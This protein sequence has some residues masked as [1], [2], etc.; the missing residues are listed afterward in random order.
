LSLRT[1]LKPIKIL[2]ITIVFGLFFLNSIMST[3]AETYTVVLTWGSQGSANNQFLDSNGIA[4]DSVGN[5]YVADSGNYRIQKFSNTGEFI[6]KWGSSGSADGYFSLPRDVVVD[7]VGNVYVADS[8]NYRIQKFSNTGEFI[9]KWG[10]RGSADSQFL[11]I[12]GIAVDSVGNVYVADPK[13]YRIQKFSNTGEFIT[14][15]GSRGSADSQFNYIYSTYEYMGIDIDSVGNVY[16]A[17]SGNRRIQKFSNTGEFITKYSIN[18]SM[19]YEIYPEQV[20]VDSSGNAYITDGTTIYKVNSIGK[21]TTIIVTNKSTNHIVVD[22]L[23]NIITSSGSSVL[24]YNLLLLGVNVTP[25]NLS[26]TSVLIAS[27]TANASGGTPPYTY[28]W[29]QESSPLEGQNS[30]ILMVIKETSGLFNFTCKVTDNDLTTVTSNSVTLKVNLSTSQP[31]SSSNPTSQPTSSSNPTSQ[32]TSSS[33]PTSQPTSSSNPTS[34][35][36]PTSNITS[37][38]IGDNLLPWLGGAVIA[39]SAIGIGTFLL[40]K[41][42]KLQFN[43]SGTLPQD[44]ILTDPKILPITQNKN[45]KSQCSS[46]DV[47]ISYSNKDRNVANAVCATLE[48]RKIRCWIAPRDV[49]YGKDWPSAIIEA[50][51]KSRIFVLVFSDS[52]NKSRQTMREV[53]RAVNKGMPIIPFRIEDVE[54][55]GGMALLISIPHWLDAITPPLEKHLQKLADTIQLLLA[56]EKNLDLT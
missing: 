43:E 23:G 22:N 47:F 6:T 11:S 38:T 17:D 15:W 12:S 10:S 13:N 32:P 49:G 18:N 51:N 35:A 42:R 27:F 34:T 33:N 39:F 45:K 8:G 2:I 21:L 40:L 37:S 16:V 44:R 31:T 29:Y 19:G 14:K 1:Y 24:K 5:V 9:T 56:D 55:T 7:S 46:F 20:A 41:K 3:K 36:V 28:Q 4:V 25:F 52:S 30:T 48:G 53:E 54:P 50:L 26:R